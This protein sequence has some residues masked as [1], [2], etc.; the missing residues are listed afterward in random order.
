MGRKP[1][2]LWSRCESTRLGTVRR[3]KPRV[4]TIIV[5]MLFLGTTSLYAGSAPADPLWEKALA[6]AR[7]NKD[8]V[9]GLV[10]TRT[11]V[12]RKGEKIGTHEFWQRSSVGS[13]G[14]VIKQ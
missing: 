1:G 14:E 13:A 4:K 2:R 7:A 10:I 11:E 3:M 8:W 6:V 5:L 9:A 12:L